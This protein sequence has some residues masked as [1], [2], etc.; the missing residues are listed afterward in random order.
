LDGVTAKE[1]LEDSKQVVINFSPEDIS[2]T[3][4]EDVLSSS[5]FKLE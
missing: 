2:Y 3:E 5:G 1:V 4:L